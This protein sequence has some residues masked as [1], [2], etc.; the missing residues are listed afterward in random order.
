MMMDRSSGGEFICNRAAEKFAVN[1]AFPPYI[2]LYRPAN[3]SSTQRSR[4]REEEAQDRGVVADYTGR[5]MPAKTALK[6]K[7]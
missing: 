7:D 6:G 5:Q 4:T 3:D 1:G 2:K